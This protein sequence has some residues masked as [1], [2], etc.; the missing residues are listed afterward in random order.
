MQ[1]FSRN[2]AKHPIQYVSDEESVPTESPDSNETVTLPSRS[3]SHQPQD[4]PESP[5]TSTPNVD[6]GFQLM[7]EF[8]SNSLSV[9]TQTEYQV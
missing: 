9:S 2:G 5:T 3:N 7:D 8:L 1:R 6:E 4:C